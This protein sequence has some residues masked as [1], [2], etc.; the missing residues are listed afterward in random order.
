MTSEHLPSPQSTPGEVISL[1]QLFDDS[2]RFVSLEELR[3]T[4]RR[5][6]SV[7]HRRQLMKRILEAIDVF[8]S[9]RIRQ[10]E[11]QLA[12]VVDRRER[13]ARDGG[14]HRVLTSLADLGDLLG[15][16]LADPMEGELAIGLKAIDRRLDRIF[17]AYGFERIRTVGEVFDPVYHELVGEREAQ[18]TQ[19]GTIIEE[20]SRGFV[21]DDHVLRPARVVVAE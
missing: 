4:G 1:Q 9:D 2:T 10:A 6:F 18:G 12:E 15:P 7:V 11:S 3:L 14:V 16:I 20:L 19:P 17:K 8:V 5:Q 13:E 21:K